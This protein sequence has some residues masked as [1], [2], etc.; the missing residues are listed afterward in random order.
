MT[1]DRSLHPEPPRREDDA[2]R[3][4]YLRSLNVLD[5]P[6]TAAL[7]RITREA[8]NIIQTP[9][10][11]VSLVDQDRQWFKSKIGLLV[12]ETPRNLAFCAHAIMPDNPGPFVVNDPLDD[13]RFKH[14]DL[15]HNYPH[16]R[17][18]AGVPLVS[19]SSDDFSWSLGTLCIIDTRP[20][21]IRDDEIQKLTELSKQVVAEIERRAAAHDVPLNPA[22]EKNSIG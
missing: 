17:F 16:I 2:M 21:T 18:Y 22:Y 13:E 3:V 7:D 15:V 4:N 9:I 5:T 20:R 14:S 11:L 8:S 12:N 1:F 10:A 6:P 19:H